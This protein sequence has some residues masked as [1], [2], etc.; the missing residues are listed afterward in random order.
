MLQ[1]LRD[2]TIAVPTYSELNSIFMARRIYLPDDRTYTPK[3]ELVLNR[4]FA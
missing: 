2:V 4:R 3:E 1:R